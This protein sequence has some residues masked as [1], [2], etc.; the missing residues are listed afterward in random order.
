MTGINDKIIDTP[1]K[2][3][4]D[5][6][7]KKLEFLYRNYDLTIYI[8]TSDGSLYAW[9]NNSDGQLGIGN[10]KDNNRNKLV[11]VNIN[12]HIKEIIVAGSTY[13]I[14][15]NGALY[16]WGKN[17]YGQLGINSYEDTPTPTKVD[18]TEPVKKIINSDSGSVY[19][20]VTDNG[21]LYLWGKHPYASTL[22]GV[23]KKE[24]IIKATKVVY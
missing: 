17:D 1:K 19:Y 9:G 16:S 18:I 2:V 15:K 20:A 12:E 14:T 21:S 13:A 11:K 24:N 3:N 6:K 23:E 7:I 10:F 5:E 4:I 22:L 8:L